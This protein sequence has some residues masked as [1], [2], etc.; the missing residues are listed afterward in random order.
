M[1]TAPSAPAPTVSV[2][3]PIDVLIAES[4]REFGAGQKALEA[5]HLTQARE[6]FDRAVEMLL[7]SQYGARTEPRL[8]IHFD[9]L[10]DRIN[11]LE[12][13]ALRQGDGFTEKR[14]DD[15]VIDALLADST[16]APPEATKATREA[17]E[18]DIA[19][20]AKFGSF[21]IALNSRV[22]SYV[23]AFQGSL[24]PFLTEGL[25]RAGRYMPMIERVFREEG[26]PLELAYVPLIES[27]FKPSA[28]SRVSAQGVWQFMVP[29]ARD[30]GLR[31]DWFIDERS[32]PEKSTV[33]AARYLKMLHK[34]FDGD[35]ALALASY[36][37]GQ[38]RVQRAV[39]NSGIN[40]FWGLTTTSTYLPRETREYVP[41]IMAAMV[42]AKNPGHYGFS[43]SPLAPL[44][45]D[46]VK[47]PGAVDLRKVAEWAGVGLSDI[48][49]LNPELRRWTTPINYPGYQLK[50]PVGRG[51][52][53]TE[54][55]A[56]V[57][58]A[59]LVAFRRYNVRR[60][61]TLASVATKHR[62]SRTEL[63]VA[64]G[65]GTRARL[66]A[67]QTLIIPRQPSAALA[68]NARPSSGRSDVRRASRATSV[69]KTITY[70]VRKG[71][72]LGTIASRHKVTVAELKR[73]NK[74]RSNALKI[75]ARLTIRK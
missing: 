19:D 14:A 43:L 71:D 3:D 68:S 64:N 17:V 54:R 22:L 6:A 16:F 38:G 9:R 29:T 12:V 21:P 53:L 31:Y 70:R 74:M 56:R 51:L 44:A 72:T 36:N 28:K 10:V 4:E 5:G 69:P 2:S 58:P 30:F 57:D 73:W 67:G 37:G 1:S 7:E 61:E 25:T 46:T 42:I 23:Q 48:E 49:D 50:V 18:A 45:Y 39:K 32:D 26:V 8:R 60:G 52:A 11:A 13:I 47:V 65:L 41:M 20:L 75:G 35:W 40:D 27:A 55:F 33:A 62:I 34:I 63:A 15:A 59:E 24:R 66:R